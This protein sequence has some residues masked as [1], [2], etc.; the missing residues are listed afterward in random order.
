MRHV[1]RE[2][3][4]MWTNRKLKR[5]FRAAPPGSPL[6][7]VRTRC[8]DILYSLER[9]TDPRERRYW[10]LCGE[11]RQWVQHLIAKDEWALFAAGHRMKH[12]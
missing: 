11:C 12:W 6:P 5:P 2:V 4:A 10:Y 9:I 7:S 8:E 3:Y 1:S